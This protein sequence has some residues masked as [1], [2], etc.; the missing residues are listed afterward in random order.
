M[1]VIGPDSAL[2]HWSLTI[3]WSVLDQWSNVWIDMMDWHDPSNYYYHLPIK[4]Y[5]YQVRYTNKLM[6][7]KN[8]Q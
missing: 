1:T 8:N 2:A 7:I 3:K 6:I 5:T 4:T